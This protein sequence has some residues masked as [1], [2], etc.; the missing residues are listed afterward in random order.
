MRGW[1][2]RELPRAPTC[3]QVCRAVVVAVVAVEARESPRCT[4]APGLIKAHINSGAPAA[5]A[6]ADAHTVLARARR[7]GVTED[8]PMHSAIISGYL[9][10]RDAESA[11]DVFDNMVIHDVQPDAVSF[12]Q[13]L[14][15][16][17]L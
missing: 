15:C 1:R 11:E 16:C 7:S 17:S 10:A 2:R 8:A 5:A 4:C 14:C 13:A 9:K 12:T 3:G 6:A